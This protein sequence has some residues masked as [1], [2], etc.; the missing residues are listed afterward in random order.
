MAPFIPFFH[1]SAKMVRFTPLVDF[2]ADI[3]PVCLVKSKNALLLRTT[4]LTGLGRTAHRVGERNWQGK[5]RR[6]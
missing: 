3:H 4:L 1:G 2:A 6:H 5:R